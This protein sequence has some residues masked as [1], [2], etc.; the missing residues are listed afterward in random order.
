MGHF[1]AV[2]AFR[3]RTTDDVVRVLSDYAGAHGVSCELVS[4]GSSDEAVDALVFPQTNGWT[5]VLWPPFFNFYD[6][7]LCAYASR[8][9]GTLAATVNVDDGDYW[10]HILFD[11]G[12]TVD[13]FVSIPSY[14]E[15]DEADTGAWAG[16]PARLAA[17]LGRDS[18]EISPYLVQLD[19]DD[20]V[21]E[22]AFEDDEFSLDD[23]WVFTD[24]WQRMGIAY[25]DDLE[26]YERVLRL[27]TNVR[28][29]LPTRPD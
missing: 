29:L 28:E 19:P 14:F 7:P 25:P 26:S 15:V 8:E 24:M 5:V 22:K 21:L 23:F 11:R 9:L 12:E 4:D 2:S 18:D 16:N 6:A 27:G 3:D 13:R 1:L 20:E 17:A 10:T